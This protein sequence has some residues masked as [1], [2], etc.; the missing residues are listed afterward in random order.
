MDPKEYRLKHPR[1]SWCKYKKFYWGDAGQVVWYECLVKDK[2][3]PEFDWLKR[4]R[5]RFCKIYKPK[6]VDFEI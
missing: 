4:W 6:E 3:I 5:G 1:C 2:Y